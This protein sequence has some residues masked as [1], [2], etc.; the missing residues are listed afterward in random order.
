MNKQMHDKNESCKKIYHLK[1]DREDPDEVNA[2]D[3]YFQL[4]VGGV[5]PVTWLLIPPF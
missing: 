2:K 1:N 4:N 5:I 3:T